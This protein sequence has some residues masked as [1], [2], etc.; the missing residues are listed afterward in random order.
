[1]RQ[2]IPKGKPMNFK[3]GTKESLEDVPLCEVSFLRQGPR[4][5]VRLKLPHNH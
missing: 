5:E 2:N 3:L 4:K 1:M